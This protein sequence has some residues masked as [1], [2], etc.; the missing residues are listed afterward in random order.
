MTK[1]CEIKEARLKYN[2]DFKARE[3]VE[4]GHRSTTDKKDEDDNQANLVGSTQK[5]ERTVFYGRPVNSVIP[6]TAEENIEL[7]SVEHVSTDV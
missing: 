1:C 2:R 5:Y 6:T 3:D 7:V 4:L